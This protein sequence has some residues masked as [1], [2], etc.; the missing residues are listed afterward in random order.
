MNWFTGLLGRTSLVH[1]HVE[2]PKY[3][4]SHSNLSEASAPSFQRQASG[5][6]DSFYPV[7]QDDR[8]ILEELMNRTSTSS[9]HSFRLVRAMR[10]ENPDLWGRYRDRV[11]RTK[12][13][14][15]R[16]SF[17]GRGAP[18]TLAATE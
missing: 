4:K 11:V 15:G 2:V 8:K 6:F 14:R 5:D 13:K 3:W 18:L 7:P 10:V 9:D 17:A 16:C 1:D 12:R